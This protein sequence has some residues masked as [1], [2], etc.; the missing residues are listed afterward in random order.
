MSR[1]Y[2]WSL[3][4]FCGPL[5]T[6]VVN[7]PGMTITERYS[8]TDS[9]QFQKEVTYTGGLDAEGN[10]NFSTVTDTTIY[11]YPGDPNEW[12][13]WPGSTTAPPLVSAPDPVAAGASVGDPAEWAPWPQAPS[14]PPLVSA[15]V[16]RRPSTRGIG[17]STAPHS[18]RLLDDELKLDQSLGSHVPTVPAELSEHHSQ[19]GSDLG[20]VS[21]WLLTDSLPGVIHEA[22]FYAVAN[23][24]GLIGGVIADLA[25]TLTGARW[26]PGVEI[27]CITCRVQTEGF[28]PLWKRLGDHL[29][30]ESPWRLIIPVPPRPHQAEHH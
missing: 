5:A 25:V 15:R 22:G 6:C 8:E 13:P 7:A 4:H 30:H 29:R 11:H 19:T 28:N 27:G 10:W 16:R 20:D 2:A 26:Y 14:E 23:A 1:M 17:I 21:V 3:S 24:G 18:A 9:G 12:A